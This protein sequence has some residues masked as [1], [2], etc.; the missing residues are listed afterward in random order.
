MKKLYAL[1]THMLFLSASSTLASQAQPVPVPEDPSLA[2]QIEIDGVGIG[3]LN[4]RP[5]GPDSKY[6]A[7]IDFNDSSL[8]FGAAQRLYENGGIGSLGFGVLA[9]D[10]TNAGT[11][12]PL[13]I[14]QAFLD[15]QT[16]SIEFLIGRSDN[17]SS[18]IVD[19]PTIREENLITF[20]N[21]LNPFS[22]G[23]NMEEHRYSNVASFTLNQEL[24]FFEN[25]HVQHLIDSLGIDNNPVALNSAGVTFEYL[26]PPGMESLTR[27]VSAGI[28]YER[29]ITQIP[30]AGDLNQIYGGAVVNLNKSV[31]DRIDLRAFD[32]VNFGSDL[33]QFQNPSHTYQ[34]G[35]NT[36]AAAVRYLRSP[37]GK[38][39][40]Q[41]SL[42]GGYKKFFTV[43]ANSWALALTGVK[44]LGAGFDLVAQ[45]SIERRN[46]SL[47]SQYQGRTT[48]HIMEVGLIFNFG[49]TFNERISPR[50]SLLNFKHQYIPD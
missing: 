14:H 24:T 4:Y 41:F 43:Q 13:F 34:A 35:Y 45:Y 9:T 36:V 19:F 44:R 12:I 23:G 22:D 20:T 1:I 15:Y 32:L 7:G 25:V 49:A 40:F 42:T 6:K 50:R 33:S 3:T 47:A 39:G 37:F 8:L 27:L 18:H 28:G 30:G 17:P 38:P 10:E 5:S 48:E 26:S 11:G 2:P 29:Q 16:K 46:G 21:P 31:T